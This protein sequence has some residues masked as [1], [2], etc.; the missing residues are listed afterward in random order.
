LS[1]FKHLPTG[2]IKSWQ[3]YIREYIKGGDSG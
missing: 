2:V 1:E 3:L